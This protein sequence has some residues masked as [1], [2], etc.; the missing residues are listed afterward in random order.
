MCIFGK[1]GNKKL[2]SE[3]TKEVETNIN[4][5]E[6]PV[7]KVLAVDVS[8]SVTDRLIKDGFNVDIGTFGKNYSVEKGQEC[9]FNGELPYLTEKDIV[10]VDLNRDNSLN[11]ENTIYKRTL[12]KSSRTAVTV[13]KGQNYFNPAFLYSKSLKDEF[14]KVINN[15]GIIIIFTNREEAEEYLC[16][17][18]ESG[19]IMDSAHGNIGNYDW[20][21]I[22]F[23]PKDCLKGREISIENTIA[24]TII[25]GCK[26]EIEYNCIFPHI[27][28]ISSEI[29]LLKNKINET[30]A[31]I[32]LVEVD[33]KKGYCIILP[34]FKDVY[35]P[36]SNLFKEVLPV[37]KPKMFP[38]FVKNNWLDNE[39]YIF[40]KIRELICEKENIVKEY[41][42][43]RKAADERIST[44][45]NDYQFLTNILV[46]Q[47]YDEFLVDNVCE[48]LKFIGYK[49]IVNVD[50]I[51]VEGNRQEDLRI[52][53]D[54]RFTVVEIK[55]HNGNPTEDDCQA[56]LKY[57]NRN[58]KS[59]GRT[60]VHGILIIN[61]QKMIE[62]MKR[63]NPAYTKEQIDD[64]LRD[65]YTLVDT[66]Q[67]FQASRLLQE[68]L[69]TFNEIDTNLHTPGLFSA[70]PST[71]KKLGNIDN[72]YDKIMVIGLVL[73][74]EELKINDEI[75]I[76][77][78]NDY[79]KQVITSLRIDNVEVETAKKGDAVSFKV[80]KS[81][82]KQANIYINLE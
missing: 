74:V 2:R 66:W 64:A 8:E 48:V 65:E 16:V 52:L 57:M 22:N 36:I 71:W 41:E 59:E 44:V 53:D 45:R 27:P 38:Q 72:Y 7:P 75:I 19:I 1:R 40:P 69:I 82:S 37:L 28:S 12:I 39:E 50:D 26:D 25:Q 58:M 60:D 10:I 14:R 31:F 49:D 3:Q 77:D 51:L 15:G 9:G 47:G 24:E 21:P 80:D 17:T 5:C 43:K 18:T 11:G 63:D 61:H 78:G 6:F 42:N 33:G 20:I 23:A 13:E 56:L 79:F 30:V 4:I 35:K 55:G 73:G 81:V 70:I 54:G 68:D 32:R 34:Q 62:P 46:S 67:L 76:Q 29:A